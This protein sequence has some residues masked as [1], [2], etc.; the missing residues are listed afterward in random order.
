MPTPL[1]IA[2]L[3]AAG[4][5]SPWLVKRVL[6]RRGAADWRTKW[7]GRVTLPAKSG[8]RVWFHGVSVGEIHVLRTLIPA[9]RRSRPDAD[10]VVSSTT[11]TGLIEA[12]RV[13]ADLSVISWPYDFSWSVRAALARVAP[14]LIV[15]GESE[16]WPGLLLES[17]KSRIPVVVINGRLSPRSA[18]RW[19]AVGMIGRQ[20]FDRVAAFA[21]QSSDY[22]TQLQSIGVPA[23]RISVTGSIK[24]DGA[25]TGRGE[26]ATVALRSQLGLSP[27]DTVWVVGSTQEPEEAGVLDIYRRLRQPGF[28]LIIVPRHSDRFDSVAALIQKTGLPMVR[29][30]Q[31]PTTVSPEAVILIDTIGELRAVWGLAD[32]AFVGGSLDGRRGGQNMIEPA[33]C[34]AAVTFGPHTWNFRAAVEQLLA[35]G[36]AI[37]VAD[38]PA[39]LATTQRLLDPD[40]R[41]GVATRGQQFVLSQ[42]GATAKTVDV[43][44]RYLPNF[45]RYVA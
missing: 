18:R 8:P 45:C 36:G 30:S 24:Y 3:T 4:V 11:P 14:D 39:L 28:R 15:L 44:G 35:A 10:I 17:Q 7:T 9:F 31:L 20:I 41:R 34:G 29:R 13:F 6:G 21:V 19:R 33:G 43:L 40:N 27:T 12:G 22:A 37:Q 23:D 38:F 32:I 25:P 2:Y 1:D 42:Q 5:A 16:L 26:P